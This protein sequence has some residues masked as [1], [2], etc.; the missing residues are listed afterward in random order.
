MENKISSEEE[1]KPI[2]FEDII[3]EGES[4]YPISEEAEKKSFEFSKEENFKVN[5]NKRKKG[6]KKN[7]KRKD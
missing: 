5:N 6:E 4:I 7:I 3:K 2:S 1:Q